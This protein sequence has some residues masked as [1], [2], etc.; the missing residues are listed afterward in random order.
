MIVTLLGAGFL[1]IIAFIAAVGYRSFIKGRP[2]KEEIDAERCS[3][4]RVKFDKN[5]LL[6]RQVGDYKLLYFCKECVLKLFA[7]LGM[8]N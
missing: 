4:C 3:I 8:K 5:E 2:A 7:D 6:L 1:L